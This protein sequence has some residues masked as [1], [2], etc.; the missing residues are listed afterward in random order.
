MARPL[1]V[2]WLVLF[3]LGCTAGAPAAPSAPAPKADDT[4][5]APPPVAVPCVLDVSSPGPLRRVGRARVRL[6]G[7]GLAVD[8]DV[9]ALCGPLFNRDVVALAVKAG[10]GLLFEACV[11]EGY[12]QLTSRE[13]VAGAQHMHHGESQA[14]AMDASFNRVGGAT[15]SSRGLT[16]D[17]VTLSA[18]FWKAD[19]TLVLRDI[20][21]SGELEASIAFDCSAA[22]ATPTPAEPTNQ[23]RQAPTAAP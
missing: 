20:E 23:A 1:H 4:S 7:Q 2:A 8:A 18:D 22:P 16:S 14:A 5:K 12:L 13:R 9:A 6:S 19:A 17:H 11:P 10:D 21:E 3:G 15:Y